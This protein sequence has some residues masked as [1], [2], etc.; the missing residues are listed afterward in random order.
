[1]SVRRALPLLA[2][3]LLALLPPAPAALGHGSAFS[4][5]AGGGPRKSDCML[6][7][8]AAGVADQHRARAT[9]CTDGDPECDVDGATDGTCTFR[10]RL[11]L[12][13]VES[14][15]HEDTVTSA[16]LLSS[17]PEFAALAAA[18]AAV[19]TPAAI[20]SCSTAVRVPVAARGRRAGRLALSAQALMASGH[21]DNDRLVFVCR[22][23]R[24]R[25][26]FATLERKIFAT[27]CATASCHGAG[28][29]GG[30][31]LTPG[32][33]YADLV[34]VPV[35]ND[36]A[37]ARGTLRVAPGDP[38]ASF[39]LLKLTGALAPDE[40][41]AMPRGDELPDAKIDLV[42]RWIAA[43]APADAPFF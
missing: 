14:R 40:G 39:L 16:S 38:D 17:A 31:T 25:T 5:F 36:A 28:A 37:R 34:D 9:R 35:T 19:P 12:H 21:A 6:V 41:D 4:R 8:D 43:G 3:P 32:S 29:A 7:T 22:P 13:A 18:L 11:C 27:S 20:E 42:R 10:V 23:L 2:L 30:L 24:S 1:M 15:C 33:A 26:T